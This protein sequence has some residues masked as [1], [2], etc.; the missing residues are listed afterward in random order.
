MA[1]MFPD[2]RPGPIQLSA[3]MM[4]KLA[5]A[6]QRVVSPVGGHRQEQLN[7]GGNRIASNEAEDWLLI[8][9]LDSGTGSVSGSGPC[10]E[11]IYAWQE[12]FHIKNGCFVIAGDERG[13]TLTKY[14]AV[15]I[16]QNFHVPIGTLAFARHST[17]L[18]S[19]EFSFGGLC[20]AGSGF[21]RVRVMTNF[22]PA[23]SGSGG[24]LPTPP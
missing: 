10:N 1:E 2:F 18:A 5:D 23:G 3:E 9:I 16:N 14:P 4:A 19:V 8:K 12:V 11:A 20:A 17:D 21:V 6:A 13:G 15:E 22:C 7:I 24:G